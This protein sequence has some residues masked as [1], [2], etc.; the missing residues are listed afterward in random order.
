M[1]V[2]K[3]L[4]RKEAIFSGYI[5]GM[6]VISLFV[7]DAGNPEW[8]AYW[9]VKPLIVTPLISA[10]GAGLAYLVAW[11]RNFWALLL[12]GFIFMMFI[13]LGIVL[14]LNGTLWD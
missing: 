12:G 9:R 4:S 7:M 13:W 3:G 2:T 10:C 6:V 8:G 14:G 5:I 11:R 1:K